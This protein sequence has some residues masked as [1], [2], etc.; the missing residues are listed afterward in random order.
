MNSTLDRRG[1]LASMPA[2]MA[3]PM[4]IAQSRQMPFKLRTFNHV[5]LVVSDLQRS[6][7][8][9]QGLFGLP[10]Q[11][12]QGADGATLRIGSGPQLLGLTTNPSSGNRTP[13]ID[14]MCVG[15]EGFDLDRLLKHLADQGVPKS[16]EQGAMRVQVRMRGEDRGGMASGTP[17][18]YIGDPDGIILQLQDVSYCAGSGPLGNVCATPEPSPK[19]GLI[20]PKA[21]NHC[22]VYSTYAQRSNRFYQQLFGME[23]RSYQGPTAPTLA[24]GPGVEFLM[25][26]GGGT[27]A[28]SPRRASINHFCLSVEGFDTKPIVETLESFGIKPR[29]NQT[30]PA[31]ALRHYIT[32]RMENRGGAKEGTP[33]LYFTDPDGLLVQ[34]QDVSYCGG[35]G[36]LG[37][38]CP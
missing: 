28:A 7:D 30:G 19:T 13:R 25:L 11:T 4:L 2:L 12:R 3:M 14:H 34:L 10:V 15:V 22:T 26:T 36:P 6:I 32:M 24:V 8:F 1:F 21:Y 16:D 31:G 18:V 37:N 29:E 5:T 17:E 38:V 23:I 35:S 20:A 9:Y 33:E 27:N